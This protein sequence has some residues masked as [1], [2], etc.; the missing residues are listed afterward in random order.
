MDT[1]LKR[2]E[3]STSDDEQNQ[4]KDRK[5]GESYLKYGLSVMEDKHNVL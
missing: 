4:S 5:Y 3:P 1:Y 2:N